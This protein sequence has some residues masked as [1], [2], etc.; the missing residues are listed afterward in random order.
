[1]N[2]FTTEDAEFLYFLFRDNYNLCALCGEVVP[3]Y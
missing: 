3:F 2:L 1:M